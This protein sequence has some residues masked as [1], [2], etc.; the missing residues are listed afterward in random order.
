MSGLSSVLALI[1]AGSLAVTAVP[2]TAG[3]AAEKTD[4][5]DTEDAVAIGPV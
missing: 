4:V 2:M 5:S 1:C 3:A